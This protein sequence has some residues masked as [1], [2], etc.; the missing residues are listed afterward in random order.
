MMSRERRLRLREQALAMTPPLKIYQ[1]GRLVGS[2][3]RWPPESS[4]GIFDIRERDF[5]LANRDGEQVIVAAPM[6]GPGDLQLLTGFRSPGGER[7]QPDAVAHE[8]D[9]HL[10]GG[11]S[12]LEAMEATIGN[13]LSKRS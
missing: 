9:V 12:R 5:R 6:I 8:F 10:A 4:S 1:E 2:I 11:A 3:P 13:L 7:P